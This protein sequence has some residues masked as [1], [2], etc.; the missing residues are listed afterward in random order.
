[1]SGF[2]YVTSASNVQYVNRGTAEMRARLA[3]DVG[4]GTEHPDLNSRS[5][6]WDETSE[7]ARTCS[8]RYLAPHWRGSVAALCT[9]DVNT[10]SDLRF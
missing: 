7:A 9:T 1:M 6:V 2:T 4:E 8:P 5:W 3:L 10:E